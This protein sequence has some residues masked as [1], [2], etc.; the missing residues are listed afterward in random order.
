[1]VADLEHQLED[2]KKLM[3]AKDECARQQQ[4][5]AIRQLTMRVHDLT[6]VNNDLRDILS[7]SSSCCDQLNLLEAQIT[8]ALVEFVQSCSWRLTDSEEKIEGKLKPYLRNYY[9]VVHDY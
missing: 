4:M 9:I 7:N 2:L 8:H 5:E 1:M 3:K 6:N